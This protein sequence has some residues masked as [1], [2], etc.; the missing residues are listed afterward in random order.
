[1]PLV[2]WSPMTRASRTCA[3]ATFVEVKVQVL[4]LMADIQDRN[5]AKTTLVDAFLPFVFNCQRARASRAVHLY[6]F[7]GCLGAPGPEVPEKSE[8]S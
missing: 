3:R 8:W 2:A 5:L 6:V 4:G 1:M 7:N